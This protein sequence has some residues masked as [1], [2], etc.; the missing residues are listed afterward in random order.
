MLIFGFPVPQR[1]PVGKTGHY[2]AQSSA[3]ADILQPVPASVALHE[4]AGRFGPYLIAHPDEMGGDLR[5]GI[6]FEQG[7]SPVARERKARE[8]VHVRRDVDG[9]TAAE[10]RTARETPQ[11]V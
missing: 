1:G 6:E 8:Q 11:P 9:R 2:V 10:Y 5:H 3:A 4:N 7:S